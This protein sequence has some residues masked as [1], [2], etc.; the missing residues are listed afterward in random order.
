MRK[1][2]EKKEKGML[3]LLT[4]KEREDFRSA[5]QFYGVKYSAFLRNSAID[6]INRYKREYVQEPSI[7]IDQR[8]AE[9]N[10]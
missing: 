7:D 5:C 9:G 2:K 1:P 3:V 8:K 10:V 4:E 6:L